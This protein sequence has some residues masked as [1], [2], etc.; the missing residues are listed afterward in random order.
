MLNGGTSF[1]DF[2]GSGSTGVIGVLNTVVVPIIFTLVFIIFI[3]GVVNYFFIHGGEEGK[4]EE[5]RT[6]I[7]W[8]VIGIVVLFSIWGIV[9]ILLSTLGISPTG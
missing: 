9:N 8:G 7:L 4:R 2:V 3:W 6:F 5:G 1:R